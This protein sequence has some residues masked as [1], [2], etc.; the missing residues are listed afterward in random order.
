[1][2]VTIYESQKEGAI[3]PFP[4]V[5]IPRV[6]TIRF[7]RSGQLAF[8]DSYGV[9]LHIHSF[10]QITLSLVGSNYTITLVSTEEVE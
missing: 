3:S 10:H 5:T 4:C 9:T 6:S 1:M 7:W 8:L 2:N